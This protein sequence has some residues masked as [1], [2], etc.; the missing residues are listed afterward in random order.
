MSS[1]YPKYRERASNKIKVNLS[2]SF[3][4]HVEY[5]RNLKKYPTSN[6]WLA[7]VIVNS[8]Q[9]MPDKFPLY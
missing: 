1:L 8:Y 7:A 5:K 3:Y 4:K 9:T 2:R 6:F